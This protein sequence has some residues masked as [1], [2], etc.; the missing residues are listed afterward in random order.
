MQLSWASTRR[1]SRLKR[2][3]SPP[4]PLIPALILLLGTEGSTPYAQPSERAPLPKPTMNAPS[5]HVKAAS[6]VHVKAQKNCPPH[7]RSARFGGPANAIVNL[8]EARRWQSYRRARE[9]ER[10]EEAVDAERVIARYR[11]EQREIDRGCYDLSE[12]VDIGRGLF[13]RR[14]TRREGYGHKIA[15][16]PPKS[17]LQRG[18]LGGPDASGCV[19][20]HWKGG[21]AGAGDRVDNTYA[22]GDGEHLSHAEPR[23]PLALWGSGWVQ[24]LAVEMSGELISARAEALREATNS[25]QVIRR[26]LKTHGVEF[27]YIS[28]HPSGVVDTTELEGVDPDLVI[29][30][31][32]WK[33]V[34]RTLREFVLVSAQKHLG[35]Q[36][37]ELVHTPLRE[38]ELTSPH[39]SPKRDVPQPHGAPSPSKRPKPVGAP[40]PPQ[41]DSTPGDP[42]QDGVLRELTEGQITALVLF[43]ATLD[44]PQVNLPT[45]GVHQTP[46]LYGESEVVRSPEFTDRWLRGAQLFTEIGCAECHRPYLPLRAPTFETV[47]LISGVRYSVDLSAVAAK[48]HPE[49]TVPSPTVPSPTVPSPTVPSPT[50][51]QPTSQVDDDY[52][53]TLDHKSDH[54]EGALWLVPLFSDL[55]R[56]RMGAH[57]RGLVSE[58][59][60]ASDEYMT[61]RLWGLRQ[62]RPYL[63]TGEALTFEEAIKAHGGEGSE[64]RSAAEYFMSLNE[65]QKS[66]VRLFLSSLSRGPAIRIR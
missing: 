18:H 17:R 46:P 34:F 12:L 65:D 60:V 49:R 59:G 8:E 63:H 33:G 64:A 40:E 29:K 5:D 31:F 54:Q 15:H 50:A 41:R 47:T 35:M 19:D 30:P 61:R 37:E 7:E 6:H 32:G 55:K 43:L 51:A 62:T 25:Q 11:L 2:L 44:T 57:L 21:F 22:F 14:F 3:T 48:P 24:A 28:A 20:C 1:S 53:Q 42:D 23:N 39:A 10:L 13:L 36:G 26:A 45:L 56:H 4:L 16:L 58:R 9:E 52:T 27:G 66:S 38:V